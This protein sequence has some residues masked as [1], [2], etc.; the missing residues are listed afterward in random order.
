MAKTRDIVLHDGTRVP[1]LYEDRSVLALDKPVGWILGPDVEEL[2]ERNLQIALTFG[3]SHGH[4]WARTRNVKFLRFIHRLDAGTSG[5]LLFSK[6]MGAMRAYSE[7]FSGREVEKA[8]LAVSDGIPQRQE[9][10]SRTPLAPDPR[11]HGRHRLSPREGK[12]AETSFHVL[13]TRDGR[14]LIE[15]EPYTGRTHQIRL[16][17]LEA[18]CPV[19][20]DLL[21]GRPLRG[22]DRSERKLG[23][24][25]VRLA[26]RDPFTRKTV[27]I[28]APAD[29]FLRQFGFSAP[30]YETSRPSSSPSVA[31]S[32]SSAGKERRT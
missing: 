28:R 25:A 8:Y 31:R 26:Y 7:L 13:A 4:V 12:P 23:L 5:V 14:A 30:D 10:T 3:I 29:E 6:S 16:H 20:G 21:Y 18:G 9:W 15:A 32:P 22:A 27:D 1:I 17:L 11:E 19:V 2:I 24:R